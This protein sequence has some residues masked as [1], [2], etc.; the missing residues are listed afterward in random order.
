MLPTHNAQLVGWD[1]MLV[2]VCLGW[3]WAT[4]LPIFSS[5]VA[6]ITAVPYH[7]QPY[8]FQLV[9]IIPYTQLT[10]ENLFGLWRW[11][12]ALTK[13]ES[14]CNNHKT[15]GPESHSLPL[16]VHKGSR[17]KLKD[18]AGFR[19]TWGICYGGD[20]QDRSVNSVRK[21]GK[22]QIWEALLTYHSTFK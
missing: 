7:V 17:W 13:V 21:V 4:A 14:G 20:I 15:S 5:Q 9:T 19:H 6:G 3:P 16:N 18:P 22:S 2:T 10:V 12:W 11:G 8:G 1:G